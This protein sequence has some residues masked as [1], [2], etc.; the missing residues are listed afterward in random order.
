M[1]RRVLGDDPFAAQPAQKSEA[2]RAPSNKG[3][4]LDARKKKAPA[5]KKRTAPPGAPAPAD[6]AASVNIAAADDVA[7]V[8][9]AAADDVASVNIAAPE[10]VV[11]VNIA[12]ADDVASVNI[13][14]AEA[15]A[16]AAVSAP[17]LRVDFAPSR[18]VAAEIAALQV[19]LRALRVEVEGQPE[20][21]EALAGLAEVLRGEGEAVDVEAPAVT[22]LQAPEHVE[23]DESSPTGVSREL[24]S[25]DF[26]LRQWGR[27]ALRDRGEEVDP[28]GYD[29][30][31]ARRWEK[32]LDF[33]YDRWLKVEVE[34]IEH[35]PATGRVALVANHGGAIPV[36]GVVLATALRKEHPA[37]RQLRWLAEDFVFHFPYAGTWANRLGAVRACQENAERLLARECCVALFPEGVKG[38]SKRYRDRY[39]LQRFGRGGHIKLALRTRTPLVPVTIVG[40][41]DAHPLLGQSPLAAKLLGLPYLPVTPTF[42]WLGPLGMVPLPTRWKIVFG[43][44]LRLDEYE[45]SQAD[46]DVL[47]GRLNERLRATIQETLDRELRGRSGW[48]GI[49]G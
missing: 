1:A 32:T 31:V 34:G 12:E 29:P 46:D 2:A 45:P 43:A 40:S 39:K 10:D 26:Y 13:A 6:D 36:D 17:S 33:L 24:L 20:H 41:D 49:G 19:Q 35:V 30:E 21:R 27:I 8:N 15:V 4:K 18:D 22:G 5:P 44:P 9:I 23:A 48:F 28:F 7:S 14:A 11:S 25:S 16:T 42:P 38:I 3:K 37:Q 47:V